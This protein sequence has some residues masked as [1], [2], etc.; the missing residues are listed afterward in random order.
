MARKNHNDLNMSELANRPEAD[1]S[2]L[3]FLTKA[4]GDSAID[5]DLEY[6]RNLDWAS[7]TIGSISSWPLELL[8]LLNLAMLSPQPQ[9]FL[10]GLDFILLYNT[11]YGRLLRDHHPEYQGRPIG[12][13]SALIAQAPA[14]ERIVDNAKRKDQPAN[15]NYVPFFFLD[16]G[17]LEEVFLSAT[18]VQ[19]PMSLHGFHAT[20][21]DT[22]PEHLRIRRE[23]ALDQIRDACKHATTLPNLWSSFL[24]GISSSDGDIAFAAL[25]RTDSQLLQE[26]NADT[27]YLK[28]GTQTLLL[29][30]TVGSFPEKV[31]GKTRFQFV[32]IVDC[33][34]L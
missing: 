13:N 9:L 15:E 29:T 6:I 5:A 16:H 31:T 7:S 19:L 30:G 14:I 8:V 26:E 27:T 18:M 2:H 23:E 34:T 4:T 22:T 12:L 28:V 11:A 33:N 1:T 25:Y 3:A 32:R 21:Y 10:L 24:K 17:R 20:T